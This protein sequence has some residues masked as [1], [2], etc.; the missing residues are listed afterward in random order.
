MDIYTRV[1]TAPKQEQII[2]RFSDCDSR[3]RV[4]IATVAFGMGIDSPDIRCITHWGLPST[5]EEYVQETGRAGRDEKHADAILYEGKVGQHAS[6]AMIT[7]QS[8]TSICRRKLLFN[9]FLCYSD[10]ESELVV[11]CQCCDVCAKSCK[12]SNCK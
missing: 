2:A 7:Y 9:N 12:C 6:Q 1:S 11:K 10:K 8:N 3:L 5:K 4:V